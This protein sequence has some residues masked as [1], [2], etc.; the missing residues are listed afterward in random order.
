MR[1]MSA[2][3]SRPIVPSTLLG[4]TDIV[5][6]TITSDGVR[7]PFSADGT[8]LSRNRGLPG[9]KVEVTGAKALRSQRIAM[10]LHPLCHWL[11]RHGS[12]PV[13]VCSYCYM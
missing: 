13:P 5:L 11:I 7:K 3:S 8:S 2:S 4:R 10:L 1:T 6:S 9:V 12:A